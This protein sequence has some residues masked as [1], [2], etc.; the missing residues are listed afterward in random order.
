[1]PGAAGSAAVPG[2][3]NHLGGTMDIVWSLISFALCGLLLA[4]GSR[5]KW[6]D[7]YDD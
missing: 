2:S 5:K 4:A 1:M 7:K 3:R 6:R